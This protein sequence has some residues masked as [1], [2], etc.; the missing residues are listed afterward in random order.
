MEKIFILI[1]WF[2]PAY[3]A[4][5][6]IQS[7]ANMVKQV[8][9]EGLEF[10]IFCRNKDLD[11]AVLAVPPDQW[12]QYVKGTNIWYSSK[13]N[14]LPLLRE[15]IKKQQPGFL[16]LVGLYDWNFNIRPLIACKHN[17]KIISV[18]GMLH[19]GALS[20]KPLKKKIYLGLWKL[21][22]WHKRVLF[23]VNDN[24]EKEYVEQIFGK[25][26][27]I[28]V[29]DNLPLILPILKLPA[30]IPGTLQLLSIALISPMKNHFLVL[31]ALRAIAKNHKAPYELHITYNIYG[32]VKD[33]KYWERC[34]KL[35]RE[36]PENIVVKY[37]GPLL[38]TALEETLEQGQVFILPSKSENFG[39]SIIEALSAGRPVITSNNTPWVNL[40]QE[41]AGINVD[42]AHAEEMEAAICFFVNMDAPELEIWSKAAHTYAQKSVDRKA[43]REQYEEMF[44]V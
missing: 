15:E 28:S 12:V 43:I 20:V 6:P 19:P 2:Q 9:G 24:K 36:L 29:A 30:K 21:L 18:R 11:G 27:R 10:C 22:G 17:N 35:I 1:P 16:F 41:H 39:H 25:G 34:T 5:G 23:H 26:T 4:G 7:I 32:P 14:I 31:E 42:T 38:P 33:E 40:Q 8:G 3:K 13:D 44:R 37:L